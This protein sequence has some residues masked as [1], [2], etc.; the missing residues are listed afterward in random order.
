MHWGQRRADRS[1]ESASATFGGNKRPCWFIVGRLLDA[2]DKDAGGVSA[3]QH[4]HKLASPAVFRHYGMSERIIGT[5][6][7]RGT[8]LDTVVEADRV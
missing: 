8:G 6:G 1:W 3:P 7:D 4:L 5:C 2:F